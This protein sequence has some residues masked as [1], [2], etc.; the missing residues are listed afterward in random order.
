[1]LVEA[2]QNG[3]DVVNGY[4]ISR[5]DPLIRIILGNLYNFL[6][7]F[8]FGIHLRDVDCDFRLMRRSIFD[9]VQL[10]GN[11]GSI[12]V[13]MVKK[14]QTAGYVFAEAPVHHYHRQYGISQFFNW[15]RLMR[16]GRALF[17][18]W[19]KLVVIKDGGIYASESSKVFSR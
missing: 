9:A 13:E 11:T 6:V 10:T 19:W 16:V 15:S 14:M 2:L 5:N 17:D 12:C 18:L 4:K 8:A 7:R 1:L 3:V